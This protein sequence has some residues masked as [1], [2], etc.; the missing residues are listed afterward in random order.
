MVPFKLSSISNK[1]KNSYFFS[2]KRIAESKGSTILPFFKVLHILYQNKS[3]MK[4]KHTKFVKFPFGDTFLG[5]IQVQYRSS[6]HRNALKFSQ[7]L[8]QG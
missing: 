1:N 3:A 8:K 7:K 5:V 2:V 6:T 4:Q